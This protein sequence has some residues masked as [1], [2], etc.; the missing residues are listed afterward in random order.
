M[1]T[2]IKNRVVF[3]SHASANFALA[4]EIRELLEVR[5]IP[6][7][8]APRDIPGT[9]TYFEEIVHGI[10]EC[11]V[12]LLLLTDE[13]NKSEAV[14]REIER[15]FAYQKPI[16]PLRLKSIK[17]SS[18]LEFIVASCQWV[19][20][21]DT[22]LKRRIEQV[23]NIV[24]AIEKGQTPPT[25]EPEQKTFAGSLER[26]LE[27]IL[28]H[29]VLSAVAAFMLLMAI[30]LTTWSGLHEITSQKDREQVLIN[31]DPS[32]I[33]LIKLN[34][35]S[36]NDGGVGTSRVA[37]AIYLNAKGV[38]FGDINLYAL[39]IS[40]S[41]IGKNLDLTSLVSSGGFSGAQV[42]SFDIPRDSDRL[43]LCM[44]AMHPTYNKVYTARWTYRLDNS[45]AEVR[46]VPDSE[47][48]L[49]PGRVTQCDTK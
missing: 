4:D 23:V 29:K 46:I 5:G 30:G 10:K 1:T 33:G 48:K 14:A 45:G 43:S 22:P 2:E 25:P 6:C 9:Q 20:A 16:L 37:A 19:D 13:S 39:A 8:I 42:I 21:F 49:T 7:W 35:V 12:T 17:P 3:I 44:S 41:L 26:K 40:P 15:S 28:R 32:A 36:P 18:K 38:S 24:R 11:A 27:Q 34:S 47:P 31:M